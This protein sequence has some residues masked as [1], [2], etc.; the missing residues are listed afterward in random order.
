M[1]AAVIT[2]PGDPHVLRIEERPDPA[3]R[4][5]ALRVRVRAF[6]VNRA[7]L[8]QRRGAYPAPPGWP[9]DIP[10]LE[11]AGE[12]DAIGE[13]VTGWSAGERVMGIA[14]G[15]TY[16]EY[17]VV[18]ATHAVR[19]PRSLA[20]T[21]AAAIPEVFITAH[22]AL[23]RLAVTADEWVLVHAVGSG[24]GT[25]ALQLIGIR[26]AHCIGTSRTA[27]KLARASTLGMAA[28]I[29]TGREEDLA[30]A[31]GR[32]LEGGAHAAVD[33]IGGDHFPAT[34]ASL[35][36]RGRL[37]LVG[38]TA[39]R[40]V[41]VDLAVILRNRLRIEGTVLRSRPEAEKA[42]VVRSFREQVLPHF[43][44]G[45]LRPV[46]D[47]VFPFDEV[48]EAHRLMERNATFGK[49]VAEVG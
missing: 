12:I 47:R 45:R 25:A 38:L 9:E 39:G 40:Q 30:A 23:E 42:A 29:D 8:L 36:P 37:V 35:R 10:G 41:E 34:L 11:Y 24:V 19:I 33:L 18:P 21:E 1:R 17:V 7:D 44:D 27:D 4:A 22:D 3:P 46:V 5:G 2:R 32:F 48:A 26:G 14:G 15:G 43:A 16:A 20:F 28:G 6:G 13:G 49:L 31:V